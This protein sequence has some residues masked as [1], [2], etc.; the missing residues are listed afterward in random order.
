MPTGSCRL[1]AGLVCLCVTTSR[2]D[3]QPV[4]EHRKKG[5]LAIRARAV[6]SRHCDGCHTGKDTPGESLLPVLASSYIA[7]HVIM[8]ASRSTS[9]RSAARSASSPVAPHA[10]P[11]LVE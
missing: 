10:S 6:L 8:N 9:S 5:D 1:L 2:A 3:A 4:S 11:L 7:A